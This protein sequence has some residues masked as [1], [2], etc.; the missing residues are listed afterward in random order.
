MYLCKGTDVYLNTYIRIPPPVLPPGRKEGV[1][2]PHKMEDVMEGL[3][4]C[5]SPPP[6][7]LVLAVGAMGDTEDEGVAE[8]LSVGLALVR[9]RLGEE[10]GVEP[11]LGEAEPEGERV[12][13][14]EREGE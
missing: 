5:V 10:E 1:E 4:E 8:M 3:V 13:G 14:A 2:P 12:S 7:P 6:K 9:V 11:W